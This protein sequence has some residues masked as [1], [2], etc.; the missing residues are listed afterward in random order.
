MLGRGGS[1]IFLRRGAPLRNDVTDGEV[2]N[3]KQVRLYEDESF[4]S[5]E[6]VRTPCTLPLD[7]PLLWEMGSRKALIGTLINGRLLGLAVNF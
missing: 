6:G 7:P 3:L 5:G 4:I 1:R 2:K